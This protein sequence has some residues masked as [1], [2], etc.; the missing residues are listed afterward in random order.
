MATLGLHRPIM[1]TTCGFSA[2]PTDPAAPSC[3]KPGTIHLATGFDEINDY[4]MFACDEH[5]DVARELA[6]DW[7]PLGH[8]CGVP[9][10]RW[11]SEEFQGQGYCWWPAEDVAE[12]EVHVLEPASA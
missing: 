6:A 10:T 3:E 9:D 8:V 7:H 4:C 5:A 2:R 1:L 12:A 11:H